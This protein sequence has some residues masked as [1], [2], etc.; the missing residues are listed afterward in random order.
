[1]ASADT[2]SLNNGDKITG[3]ILELNPTS[4][5]VQTPYA[6]RVTIERAA[7]KTMQSEKAVAVTSA[8]GQK[9]DRYLSPA[10]GEKGWQESVAFVPP[11]PP[12]PA[13]RPPQTSSLYIRR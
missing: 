13:A 12:A 9:E 3:T 11:P 2:V 8:A 7:V 1:L 5:V 10:P 4:V 6:V